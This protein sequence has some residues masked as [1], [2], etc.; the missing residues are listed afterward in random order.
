MNKGKLKNFVLENP[1]LVA[2]K[3]AG[4]GIYVLKYKKRVFYDGTYGMNTLKSVV[5]PLWTKTSMLFHGLSQKSTTTE[6]NRKRLPYP[7]ILW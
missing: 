3:P 5:A 4:E 1:K 7:R 2:M 6:S